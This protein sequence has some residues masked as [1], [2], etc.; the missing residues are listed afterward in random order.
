MRC[1]I[2]SI[3]QMGE[4]IKGLVQ[5]AEMKIPMSEE[6]SY[7]LR[8]IL[9]ELITNSFKHGGC[10]NKAVRVEVGVRSDALEI[11]VEDGG[12]GIADHSAIGLV[13]DATAE[14]GRGLAIVKGLCSSLE[15]NESG[16]CV[17]ARL[18]VH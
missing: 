9:S 12:R 13:P 1:Q 10:A 4:V 2:A 15:L 7:Y 18:S 3:A 16:N 8:L 11:C 6:N 5:Y 14:S 17:T